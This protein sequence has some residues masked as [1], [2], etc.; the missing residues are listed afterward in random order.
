[1]GP[2]AEF[3]QVNRS[4]AQRLKW[5][6]EATNNRVHLTTENFEK[7]LVNQKDVKKIV[8]HRKIAPSTL[9]SGLKKTATANQREPQGS[10]SQKNEGPIGPGGVNFY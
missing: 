5:R 3:N 1:M 2:F 7:D 10:G 8:V 6:D 4:M 9:K